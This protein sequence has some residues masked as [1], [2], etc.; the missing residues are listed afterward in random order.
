[1]FVEL[2]SSL[3]QRKTRKQLLA[4]RNAKARA[5]AEIRIEKQ[6]D[7]RVVL[8]FTGDGATAHDVW[9]KI[10]KYG[11]HPAKK[12]ELRGF[13]PAC[14]V[15]ALGSVIRGCK[16]F[17]S[18]IVLRGNSAQRERF[19][20]LWRSCWPSGTCFAGILNEDC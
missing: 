2:L 9:E 18:M 16:G 4:H 12:K 17:S 3:A 13:R 7:S 6:P 20:W 19:R 8:F 14:P 1:M 5:K 10:E 11:C 15:I